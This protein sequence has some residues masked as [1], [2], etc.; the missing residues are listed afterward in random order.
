[1]RVHGWNVPR[2]LSWV[3]LALIICSAA[4]FSPAA[5]A[6]EWVLPD[7]RIGIRT[8]P[9][10]LL[11][12]PDVQADLRLDRQQIQGALQSINELT[13]RASALRGKTGSAVIAERRAI[14]EAQLD[15][16]GKN[17]TGNQLERL[18][19][20]ELQ[21][22]GTSAMLSRPTVAEYLKLTAEQRQALARV[23]SEQN[24][25]RRGTPASVPDDRLLFRK[26]QSV[27]SPGQ[28]ELWTNLLGTPVRFAATTP[29]AARRTRDN[30]AQQAGHVQQKP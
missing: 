8:A 19:Q 20:V 23:I 25:L 15:W 4:G 22:E 29:P 13:L 18:H 27:L 5:T 28:Q 16:L 14:D 3:G 17:L 21:W 2:A 24:S 12:R 30:A 7:N 11:S 26:A 10:L 1:M 6:G 9:L